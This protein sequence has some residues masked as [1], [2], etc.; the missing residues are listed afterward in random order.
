MMKIAVGHCIIKQTL[1]KNGIVRVQPSTQITGAYNHPKGNL[2][3][4]H[5]TL[6]Q[7]HKKNIKA[8]YTRTIK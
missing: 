1:F 7:I 3:Q 4:K 5:I 8:A 2:L 6:E